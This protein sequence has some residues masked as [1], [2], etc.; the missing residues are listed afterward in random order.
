[1]RDDPAEDY[2]H[3]HVGISGAPPPPVALSCIAAP[4]TKG[5]KVGVERLQ[6]RC[7]VREIIVDLAGVQEPACAPDKTPFQAVVHATA[8][9]SE[10]S[11]LAALL[12]LRCSAPGA[13]LDANATEPI[14]AVVALRAHSRAAT[15]LVHP[16]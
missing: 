11:T 2:P 8:S 3:L 1:V 13:E 12:W 5:E 16:R 6:G 7:S 14:R 15:W 10:G 9:Q 4:E